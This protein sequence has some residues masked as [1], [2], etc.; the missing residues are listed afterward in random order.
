MGKIRAFM[1]GKMSSRSLVSAIIAIWLVLLLGISCSGGNRTA[2]PTIP[3]LSANNA[4]PGMCLG[5]FRIIPSEDLASAEIVP[6][7]TPQFDVTKWAKIEIIGAVWDEVLR[8]WTLT[9]RVTNPTKLTGWGVQAI[10][11]NLGGKELRWPDGFTGLDLVEPPGAERYPFFA[12]EKTTPK[13]EFVGF[14]VCMQDLTFHFPEGVDKWKPIEFFIDAHLVDPRPEPM[15]EDL[16]MAY[17]PPPCYHSTALA[18]I[19]DHQTPTNALGVWV[20]LSPLGGSDV[21]PMFD[22][23]NHD[24]FAVGDGIF[25]AKFSGGIFGELYTLTVYAQDPEFN[26]GEN[27]IFYSPIEYPPLPP[28][29]FET[30]M[31]GPLCLLTEET[32]AVISNQD[33]WDYFWSIFS[34]WDM[35][36]PQVDFDQYRI[37]AVCI[38]ERPD[39]CYSV[40]VTNVDWTSEN[41]GWAVYY[42]E[43]YPGP[44]C[45]CNDFVISPFHLVLVNQAGF[46]IMFKGDTYEDPCSGTSDPCLDLFEVASGQFCNEMQQTM[47]LIKDQAS[48]ETWWDKVVGGTPP[49]IDFEN[50][51][52]Y[53]ITMGEQTSSGHFPTLD[54]ACIELTEMLKITVGWHVPGAGCITLPVMTSPYAVY[55]SK[56]VGNPETWETYV[57]EYEC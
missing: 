12:I 28:V 16:Q 47:T 21:E 18:K 38:G 43:T 42:T 56:K 41:C 22:D 24:D 10:F 15:V 25:G 49:S 44:D 19:G 36:P 35:P 14:H 11:T 20:D 39:D 53:A 13:R 23:G 48:W 5:V 34:V 17:F 7:R 1:E 26:K 29:Y 40:E 9:V 45:K 54:S 55:S 33:E 27:D 3:S 51:M 6:V 46:D 30:L 52:V 31:Q 4:T 2:N 57:D 8:N 37:V 32:L 50:E